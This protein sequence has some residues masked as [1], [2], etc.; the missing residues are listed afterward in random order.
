MGVKKGS[1]GVMGEAFFAFDYF[2]KF[3]FRYEL[4]WL[5]YDN[6]FQVDSR[7][8]ADKTVRLCV[9]NSCLNAVIFSCI[10]T[11]IF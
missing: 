4:E 10:L 5:C 11:L 8:D 9:V 7:A 1:G 2:L 6:R 3:G